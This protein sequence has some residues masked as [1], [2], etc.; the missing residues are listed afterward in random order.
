MTVLLDAMNIICPILEPAKNKKENRNTS[1]RAKA[2]IKAAIIKP[3]TNIRR[4]LDG[5]L[6]NVAAKIAP[7]TPPIPPA[8]IRK[9]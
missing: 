8:A 7:I 3:L 6:S 9:P 4:P 1:V 5:N 2:K